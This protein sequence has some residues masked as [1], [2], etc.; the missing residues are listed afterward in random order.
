M[1]KW[2]RSVEIL[3]VRFCKIDGGFYKM[4]LMYCENIK[5]IYVEVTNT[6][7]P[8]DKK[9]NW[10]LRI[11]P[12]LEH[13]SVYDIRISD[14]IITFFI[15]NPNVRK[16]ST[17]SN[18]IW[19]NR[20]AFLNSK[21]R[22]DELNLRWTREIEV[23]F[24]QRFVDLLNQLHD[25]GFYKRL[26]I[27]SRRPE[28]GS[29]IISFKALNSLHIKGFGL[30]LNCPQFT[31]LYELILEEYQ[32]QGRIGVE[33]E[34]IAKRLLNLNRLFISICRNIDDIMPF[35][36]WSIMLTQLKVLYSK[37]VVDG[38]NLKRLNEERSRLVEPSELIIYVC[39]KIFL[40]T[41][42]TTKNGDTNL[43]HIKMRRYD[44]YKFPPH[45]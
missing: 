40:K 4:V 27:S 45:Q 12:K 20:D 8:E 25:Q 6:I 39:D 36:R 23:N 32:F 28:I 18:V 21:I 10:L 24:S 38:L 7:D 17:Y 11:Y 16:F 14:E 22:L 1:K 15:L 34:T 35:A 26:H 3:H 43:K 42:W 31:N 44:S 41:K 2:L 30:G 19:N 5:E 13:L 33:L 9:H 37:D 29:S